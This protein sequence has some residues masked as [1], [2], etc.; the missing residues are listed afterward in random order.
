MPPL[1]TAVL[2]H[3]TRA[4]SHHDWLIESPL[5]PVGRLWTARVTPP[6]PAWR[7]AG[8]LMLHEL[9]PH[10]RAYLSYQ[11]DLGG[12]RGSVRRVDTG[13]VL[14]LLWTRSRRVLRLHL[15]AGEMVLAMRRVEGGLWIAAVTDAMGTMSPP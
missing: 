3:I 12:G 14:P 13:I 6:P 1:R 11:G 2:L 5:D 10:R 15:T 9:K 8:R 4:D 7:Q